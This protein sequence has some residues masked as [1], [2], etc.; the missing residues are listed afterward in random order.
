MRLYSTDEEHHSTPKLSATKSTKDKNI[1]R[2][3]S[4]VGKH[5]TGSQGSYYQNPPAE[6]ELGYLTVIL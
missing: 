6:T 3:F 2:S 5:G 1:R 4:L